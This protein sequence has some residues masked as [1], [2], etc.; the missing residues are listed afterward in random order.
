MPDVYAPLAQNQFPSILKLTLH[1]NITGIVPVP[2][3][4][5]LTLLHLSRGVEW[6]VAWITFLDYSFVLSVTLWAWRSS[7]ASLDLR[8]ILITWFVHESRAL[9]F[10]SSCKSCLSPLLVDKHLVF[11]LLHSPQ[12]VPSRYLHISVSLTCLVRSY[13]FE[14]ISIF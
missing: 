6:L 8:F 5:G 1:S 10:V 3:V 12:S 4:L 9:Y 7:P 13:V 2:L 14:L 11:V